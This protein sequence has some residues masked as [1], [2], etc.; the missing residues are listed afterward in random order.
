MQP[1]TRFKLVKAVLLAAMYSSRSNER[2]VRVM[3]N[4][5]AKAAHPIAI[6]IGEM[7]ELDR[8][9]AEDSSAIDVGSDFEATVEVDLPPNGPSFDR[10][11]ELEREE[12]LVSALQEKRRLEAQ[13]ADLG[14]ELARIREQFATLEAEHAEAKFT[15]NRRRRRTIDEEE[16]EQL[17]ARADRDKDY[18]V[19][20][21]NDL[22]DAKATV[23]QQNRQLER[24]KSDGA[25][26]QDL[27]D[28]LQLIRAERDE[29]RQKAK[30]NENLKKKIQALQE[31]EKINQGLRGNL[32]S[33]NDQLQELDAVKDR[34]HALEKINEENVQAIANGEQEIFDQ[35]TQK[36]RL[37][38]EL[39]LVAQ[40]FEQT[41][42]VLNAAEE[43][44][45]ELEEQLHDYESNLTSSLVQVSHLD[46]ELNE[47][48]PTEEEHDRRRSKLL[49]SHGT[50]TE[51]LALQQNLSI[52]QAS[53]S[54]LEQ[55]CLDL[56]QENLGYKSIMDGEGAALPDSQ[57]FLHQAQRL[58]TATKELED[59]Q[60]KLVAATAEIADLKDRLDV[61]KTAVGGTASSVSV[62]ALTN[63]QER[64][65]Y[66]KQLE[67]ELHDQKALLRHALLSSHALRREDDES[68][69]T[70]EFQMICEQLEVVHSA[71][72]HE[73]EQ[74]ISATAMK[75]TE[76]IEN[77]RMEA[78]KAQ[79]VRYMQGKHMASDISVLTISPQRIALLD[80]ENQTLK[81]EAQ[82]AQPKLD[83]AETRLKPDA[84]YEQDLE[85]L[86]RENKL[87]TSAWFDL[88]CRLQSNTV[89]LARRQEPPKSWLSR[90]RIATQQT[91]NTVS[92]STQSQWGGGVDCIAGHTKDG[93]R[94][95]SRKVTFKLL[96]ASQRR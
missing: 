77:S 31:Q 94:W 49:H 4:L 88:T 89:L 16:F 66:T 29:L 21:E 44:N 1:L 37:E 69:N 64:Q 63:S 67:T 75:L 26:K 73:S 9:L 70:V 58:E 79:E 76:K 39:K 54:R 12:R 28:E 41:R 93:A 87:I 86:R 6:A 47:E 17:S 46:A 78:S 30:A 42:E 27:R 15:L 91:A 61:P 22:A 43:R 25:K 84:T 55:K 40:K 90:Q 60:S 56:L 3:Q 59:I 14:E 34:C 20:L 51:S 24:L 95:R 92:F 85:N 36:K 32:Q 18:I 5:G 68:L 52:A 48:A 82:T 80:T 13:V 62:G 50:S 65:K 71:P 96:T 53:V 10:D 81:S 23:E 8:K 19:E 72:V 83:A 33:V 11:P 7:E 45:R 74:V 35:K 57:P 2:M 38:H